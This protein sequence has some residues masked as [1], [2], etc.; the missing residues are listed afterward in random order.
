MSAKKKEDEPFIFEEALKQLERIVQRLEQGDVP[1]DES[2][3]MYEEGIKLSKTCAE[4]LS[5]AELTVKRLA[6]VMDGTFSL[7][8]E[9]GPE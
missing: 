4:H 8:D 7:R 5:K 2:I 6:K 1:L 3:A 9:E